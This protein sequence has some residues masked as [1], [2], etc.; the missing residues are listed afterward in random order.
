MKNVKM[1]SREPEDVL[2]TYALACALGHDEDFKNLRTSNTDTRQF[3]AAVNEMFRRWK[4]DKSS[5]LKEIF[6][7]FI[8]DN[9]Y[10][11]F[12]SSHENRVTSKQIQ[13]FLLSDSA[14]YRKFVDAILSDKRYTSMQLRPNHRFLV[15]IL[16]DENVQD[17][18]VSKI[19]DQDKFDEVLRNILNAS[20]EGKDLIVFRMYR[21]GRSSN[22]S[23]DCIE[24]KED[25]AQ[26]NRNL[27]DFAD[28]Y[29]Q[30][31]VKASQKFGPFEQI[32]NGTLKLLPEEASN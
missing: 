1:L 10:Y 25:L 8:I 11:N 27:G 23:S 29:R 3:E 19:G 18:L 22:P 17:Y 16:G 4:G 12:P 30:L 7:S 24:A 5:E 2:K 13:E 6:F 9:Y 15:H 26:L 32:S 14:N 21:N 28:I 20:L 31:V